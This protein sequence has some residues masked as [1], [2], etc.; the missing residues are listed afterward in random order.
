MSTQAG[1]NPSIIFEIMNGYVKTEALRGVLELELFTHVVAG[2]DTAEAL[3]EK[4]GASVRGIRILCDYL[5][6]HGLLSK[7][8][9]RYEA[10]REA[11]VFLNRASP[12]YM[13]SVTQFMCGPHQMQS[14]QNIAGVV[15]KGGTRMGPGGSTEPEHPI[16][17]DFARSMTPMMVPAAEEMAARIIGKAGGA[18]WRVLDIAAGH[19]MFGITIARHNHAHGH[20]GRRRVH[21]FR[22]RPDVPSSGLHAKRAPPAHHG[23][24]ASHREPPLTS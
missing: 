7:K 4:C 2:A 10:S 6:V 11:A 16:W 3:A 24:P 9:D 8:G 5:T 1:L 15:R 22:V 18:P 12:M 21:V 19:G 20:A 13:G 23:P 14:F 17:I